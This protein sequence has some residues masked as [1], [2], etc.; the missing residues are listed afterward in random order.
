[1]IILYRGWRK[2]KAGFTGKGNAERGF[3]L[4]SAYL[5]ISLLS[6]YST[7]FM[8]RGAVFLQASERNQNK[9]VAFNMAESAMDLAIAELTQEST[10]V[11]NGSTFVDLS[12][13]KDQGE[14]TNQIQGGYKVIVCLVD[15]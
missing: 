10:Y 4:L 5:M 3:V 7:A 9:I 8:T 2:S 6:V 12:I 15:V 13:K 11:N 1:M 14:Y